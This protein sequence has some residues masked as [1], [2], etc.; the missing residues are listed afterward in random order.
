M[1]RTKGYYSI[2]LPELNNLKI[3]S[4]NTQAPNNLNFFLLR[5]S[6][7]PGKM[8]EW[9]ESELKKSEAKGQLVH[10]IGHIPPKDYI[11]EWG[12]RFTALI[13][14]YSYI[15]RGQFYGH[16]HHDQ[17]GVFFSSK[18]SSKLVNYCLVAPSLQCGKHPQYR[19][20]E[21][22]YDTL[23]VVNFKQYL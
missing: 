17:A 21:V 23:Q 5:D 16:T 7:D 11:Y 2:E 6:T 10:I 14:R 20:M 19:V 8:L 15:I 12:E 13:D 1:L 18:N 22:D 9:F 3:I 4:L